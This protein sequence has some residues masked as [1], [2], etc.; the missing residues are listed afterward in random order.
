LLPITS[1]FVP[2]VRLAADSVAAREVLPLVTGVVATLGARLWAGSPDRLKGV[3]GELAAVAAVAG[4]STAPPAAGIAAAST[5]A[6]ARAVLG[7]LLGITS[8]LR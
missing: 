1:T 7:N 4:T 2:A 8:P 6:G 3:C 5:R